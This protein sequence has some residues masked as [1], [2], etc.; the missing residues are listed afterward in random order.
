MRK[1]LIVTILL[2]VLAAGSL[3]YAHDLVDERKD[4]ATIEETVLY[5]DKSVAD[6]ITADIRTHCDYRLFWDTR[7]TVGENPEISTD[8]TFSQTKIYTSRT[9]S[10]HGIYFDSTFGDYGLSTTGSIDMADQSALAKDVASRTE[11]GEERTERVYI[12]DYFDFYPI[13][14]NFDTPF[15]G[16]AVNEETLAIFADYFRIP[17]HP[18]HRVEISIEKDS[19]GKI[20]SIGTSTIKDGSVDLKAEGVVT[21][22]SC[23]FTLSFRT[24]DGKLLDTSHIPGGYGIYYFPLH[25]EDGNDGI[26]T[27]DE[28][29][30]VFRIDSERAE[31][32][33]LQTNAQKNRLLLVTIENGAYMLTVID[34]ETMKQLQKLEILKAVEGSV[35]RNL[36]IYDDFIVPAVNDGRFALLA[37]DGSGNYEVRFTAQFNEYEELGY[38][39]SNEVSMDYNGE[40]LAVSAFQDGWNASR[41]N[42]SFYL[43][44]Y[45]R[46][47]LTYVG[48]YEHSLDK[49]FADNVPAC[50][51]VNKDP[52]IVTWS[53]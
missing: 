31:V 2:L 28:L 53:D 40:E 46:T 49:S 52:L 43:A 34:A 48:N 38:I 39:F 11:P 25:N 16:F 8:F 17:V 36:Y 30:M 51:P 10:Y 22:D 32:V 7:Y 18:E 5:G 12:K 44:I 47:G 42:N 26:L 45:D 20:F 29:Q 1:S 50:I 23:F 9:I 19:A 14:V 35:F 4:K 3:Y 6:G 27:A 15:I 37:P 41:K 24:E 33:S 13:I 21:D